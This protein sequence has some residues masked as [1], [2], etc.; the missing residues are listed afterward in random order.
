MCVRDRVNV[1]R[2][3]GSNPQLLH[4][5][6]DDTAKDTA[7]NLAERTT[8]LVPNNDTT[9]YTTADTISDTAEGTTY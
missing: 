6:D 8:Y 9:D 7:G 4:D 3:R 5:T 2:A 1:R